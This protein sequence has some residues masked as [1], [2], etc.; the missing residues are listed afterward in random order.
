VGEGNRC[1]NCG[2]R[3]GR[4]VFGVFR[5]STLRS[6][7]TAFWRRL[8]SIVLGGL[9][10][11]HLTAI[12]IKEHE[13]TQEVLTMQWPTPLKTHKYDLPWQLCALLKPLELL[14]RQRGSN[15]SREILPVFPHETALTREV[16]RRR[17]AS[18]IRLKC[19]V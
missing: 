5:G 3:R 14:G 15:L 9:I 2:D 13:C 6:R 12:D 18:A 16:E 4:A 1:H 17:D 8:S 11:A 19:I 7:M 10:S